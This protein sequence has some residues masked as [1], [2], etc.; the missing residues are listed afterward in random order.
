VSRARSRR[1]FAELAQG[2]VEH[3]EAWLHQVAGGVVDADG[4]LVTNPNP[5]EAI[6]LFIQL[7]EFTIPRV[8]ASTIE[9]ND[10]KKVTR[11]TMAELQASV[12]DEQ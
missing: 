8:K 9:V 11:M 12:V 10:G 3:V 7:A 6:L 1:A 5:R 2:N 4:K